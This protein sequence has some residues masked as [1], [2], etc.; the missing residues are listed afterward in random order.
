VTEATRSGSNVLNRTC[1]RVSSL[2]DELDATAAVREAF[3][4]QQGSSR[5]FETR[6]LHQPDLFV[7][8]IHDGFRAE[9]SLTRDPVIVSSFDL[10]ASAERQVV[11]R[12]FARQSVDQATVG[13][14]SA[15]LADVLGREPDDA[16]CRLVHG[17]LPRL[18]DGGVVEYDAAE[19][20]VR[21]RDTPLLEALLHTAD[22]IASE[23]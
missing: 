16:R 5:C 23:T 10:L 7:G 18:A 13:E 12:Y 11:I 17:T 19:G 20:I 9:A 6:S 14:L 4:T 3:A 21:D 8:M 22:C 2:P 15:V 1:P